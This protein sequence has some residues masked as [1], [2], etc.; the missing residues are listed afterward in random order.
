MKR[1]HLIEASGI[2]SSYKKKYRP[3]ERL[4]ISAFSAGDRGSSICPD[5]FQ[6]LLK[7][8]TQV[9]LKKGN[10][11]II[12][13]FRSWKAQDAARKAYEAGKKRA[14]VAPAGGSFHTSGRAVDISVKE[15]GFEGVE[16]K[17]WLQLFWDLAKPLG[18]RPIITVPDL[19][20]S[21]CWHFDFPGP[22]AEAY[23]KLSYS[24]VAKCAILDVGEW[25]PSENEEKVQ[26]MFVQSQLIRLGHYTVGTI[27]G[28]FGPKTNR[29]LEMVG[30]KDMSLTQACNALAGY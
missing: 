26:R 29:V 23:D 13:L 8:D 27:D 5:M 12:D 18:F 25:N 11:Y 28:V 9:K 24:E 10:F 22:W 19:G 20:M 7:L 21:E 16:K 6:A 2:A 14:Y 30:L 3:K 4:D 15:L 1:V 17:D